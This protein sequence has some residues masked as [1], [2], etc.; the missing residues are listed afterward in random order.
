MLGAATLGAVSWAMGATSLDV[1]SVI[2]L[3]PACPQ[4]T[5]T[6]PSAGIAAKAIGS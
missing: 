5:D 2:P 4:S 3:L 1:A 6:Y